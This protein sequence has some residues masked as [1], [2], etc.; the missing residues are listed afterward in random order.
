MRGASSGQI[1]RDQPGVKEQVGAYLDDSPISLSLFT[2]DLDLFD[3]S[4][5]QAANHSTVQTSALLHKYFAASL[6]LAESL[7]TFKLI[8]NEFLRYESTLAERDNVGS[9][10]EVQD[11]ISRHAK[12]AQQY[13]CV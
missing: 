5:L 4:F 13:C 2:P 9:V 7:L 3:L 6:D 8:S 1:A 10:V 12:R 11:L